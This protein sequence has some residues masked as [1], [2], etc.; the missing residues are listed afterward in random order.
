V[1]ENLL[2]LLGFV[3]VSTMTPGPNNMMVLL[4]GANWG[5]E[6]SWPHIFGIAAGFPVMI[7]AVGLGLGL[8]FEAFPA[9][10]DILKWVGFAYLCWLAWKI[11][12]AGRP[13]AGGAGGRPMTF[14]EAAAFQWVNPKA[15][16]IVLAG[17]ALYTT[18][19]GNKAFEISLFALLFGLACIP[20]GVV[21]ALFGT[22]IAGLLQDDSWR[23]RFNI[24]MAVL[25]V[26][27]T[28]PT[29]F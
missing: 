22:A 8:A 23:R 7:V 12:I 17:V 24:A 13:E 18:E 28:V 26:I 25:L 2:P 10:H 5:L 9:L 1:T 4:S 11:A 6:R 19:T 27:S 16:A 15:W 14:L 29:L 21:W 3:I 20:N